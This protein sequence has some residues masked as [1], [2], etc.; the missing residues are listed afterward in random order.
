MKCSE[1]IEV[2]RL[3]EVMISHRSGDL[4]WDLTWSE[5]NSL[6]WWLHMKCLLCI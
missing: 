4:T 5:N 1:D 2:K 3:H 6:K